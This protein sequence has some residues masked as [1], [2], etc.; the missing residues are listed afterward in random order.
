M[1]GMCRRCLGRA[2]MSVPDGLLPAHI[3]AHG[4]GMARPGSA[5]HIGPAR[6]HMATLCMNALC[7]TTASLLVRNITFCRNWAS[8]P[9][10]SMPHAR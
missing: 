2:A 4:V 7:N 9:T 5:G 1:V 8:R 6:C 3:G 10:R